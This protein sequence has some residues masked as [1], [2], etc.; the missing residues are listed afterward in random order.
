LNENV[1]S[2]ANPLN[3]WTQFINTNSDIGFGWTLQEMDNDFI[4]SKTNGRA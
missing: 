3:A 4:A 1:W 2:S